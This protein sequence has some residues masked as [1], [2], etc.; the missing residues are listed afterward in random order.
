[1]VLYPE[2]KLKEIAK[3]AGISEGVLRVF[4]TQ[5]IF[6]KAVKEART[7]LGKGI[8]DWIQGVINKSEIEAIKTADML[9]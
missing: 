9:E 3:M 4:R 2:L 7:N 5:G 1:M 8:A 6:K